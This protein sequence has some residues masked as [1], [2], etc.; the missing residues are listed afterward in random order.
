MTALRGIVPIAVTPFHEDGGIDVVG[1]RRVIRLLIDSGAHGIGLFGNA[2]E[3][4]T[5]AEDE[6]RTLMRAIVEETEGAVPLIA[7]SGHTGTDCAV[8][9]SR[10]LEALGAAALMIL[11][12]YY[13]KPDGEGVF[14][15]Y[16]AISA[17]V[18]IPIMVQ[19]APLLTQVPL[20]PEL[21]A[22]MGRE[23]EN[24]RLVKVE[25]PPTS[26]KISKLRQLAPDT[27]TLF[28]GHH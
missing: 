1:Q 4:Y 15:Y 20:S 17:A 21:L 8:A 6:R 3:G 16:A 26:T 5:L 9:M 18:K 13:L 23:L 24:V 22:R 28:G 11:P 2:S 7:S 10:D 12:P 27:L 14:Q 19:D 25:A